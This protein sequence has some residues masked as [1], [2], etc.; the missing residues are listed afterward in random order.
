MRGQVFCRVGTNTR[1]TDLAGPVGETI[2]G[3]KLRILGVALNALGADRLVR[4]PG[5]FPHT[6]LRLWPPPSQPRHRPGF[7]PVNP[8]ALQE[9]KPDPPRVVKP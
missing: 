4:C 8:P 9:N 7:S 3:L 5:D 6:A 1:A 2:G